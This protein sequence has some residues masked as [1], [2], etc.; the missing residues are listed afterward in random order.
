MYTGLGGI[1]NPEG[2]ANRSS[3]LCHHNNGIAKGQHCNDRDNEEG[4]ANG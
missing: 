3:L 2:S 4:Q 1:T